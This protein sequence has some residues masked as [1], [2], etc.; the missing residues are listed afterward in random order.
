MP[1]CYIAKEHDLFTLREKGDDLWIS[2]VS[3]LPENHFAFAMCR[4]RKISSDLCTICCKIGRQHKQTIAHVLSNCQAAIQHGRFNTSM[5]AFLKFCTCTWRNP[6]QLGQQLLPTLPG[7]HTSSQHA[8]L[9][10]NL[11][12]VIVV[13]PLSSSTCLSWGCAGNQIWERKAKKREQVPWGNLQ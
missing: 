4:W 5:R 2:T 8:A 10:P 12:H 7:S 1:V 9:L 3:E 11:R 6:S 13:T